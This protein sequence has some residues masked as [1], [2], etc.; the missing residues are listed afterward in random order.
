MKCFIY[1]VAECIHEKVGDYHRLQRS[2]YGYY[3]KMVVATAYNN[4]CN[5]VVLL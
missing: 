3:N 2:S 5:S 1:I 4:V